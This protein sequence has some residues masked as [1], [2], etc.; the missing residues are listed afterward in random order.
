MTSLEWSASP[1][2]ID[3]SRWVS[4]SGCRTVLVVAHT[5]TSCQ[6]LLDVIEY[7]ESDPRVQ[8]VFTVAPD[9]FNPHVRRFL[10]RLG[11][12]VLPWHQA[13]RER[14][15]LGLAAAYGGLHQLHAP[16]LLMAHGAGHSKR[17]RPASYGGPVL[18]E[19]PVY[20]LDAQRLTHGG[21]VLP[22]ALALSHDGELEV[23]RRQCPEAVEAAVVVGDPCVDRL[24][25]SLPRR[26]DYRREMGLD[27]Q[28][29]LVV[30]SSTWGR[31]GVFGRWPD[32]LPQLMT[33]L[34]AQ[35][36]RIAALLHPAVW[37]A[38]GHRQ[39]R[40]WLRDCR[41]GGLLLPDP[42][43][44]WRG[45]V[46][47]ADHVIGDHGSVTAYAAAIGR[48]T[49]LL[50][51]PRSMPA[52]GTAQHLLAANATHL[53]PHRPL[54]PQLALAA[55]VDP[56]AVMAALTARPGEAG[57]LLRRTMYRL[58]QL[59]EPGRHR[60]TSPV[61]MPVPLDGRA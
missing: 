48:P 59:A 45:P 47:A 25:A 37:D 44:D 42:T 49:L 19:P 54:P 5:I 20:G 38:H 16:L 21:R 33:Q 61:P 34:P 27:E 60:Q 24:V 13:V 8:L 46:V 2:G 29:E 3:A 39:I 28:Q 51:A 31:D 36:Y 11:A 26:P 30:V 53:D 52:A 43:V 58:L 18:A 56:Q 4:R 50:P 15:D 10:D 32:L 55:T 57:V 14:F 23:L 9:V 35:R 6:R 12:L 41:D 1:I 22:T 17:V 7:V 40:A